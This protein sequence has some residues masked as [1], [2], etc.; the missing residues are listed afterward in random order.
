MKPCCG[1]AR[2]P[3]SQHMFFPHFEVKD[4]FETNVT[5]GYT[6]DE[7]KRAYSYDNG[8][9]G[10]GVRVAVISALDN[11]ALNNNLSVFS[12]T[13]N[14]PQTE[15]R[16]FYPYGRSEN[17]SRQWLIESS[18]DTQWIHA[19]APSSDI[20][21]VFSPTANVKSLLMCAEYAAEQLNCDIVCMCFGTQESV[22]DTELAELMGGKGIFVA[23]SGDSGGKVSFPSN[24]PYCI[25]V[26]GTNLS[27]SSVT[28]RRISETAWKNGGGGKSDVF[29]IPPYQG[30]FFNIYGMADGMRGTPD[31]SLMANYSP[32]APVY[33]S[34]LGGWTNV[35]GTSLSAACFSGICACI[36][37]KH[38]EITKS[39]D[40]LSFLYSK[41][42]GDGYSLPQYNFY[43]ITIG[44]SGDNYAMQGWDFATG[45]GSPV[46]HRL[47]T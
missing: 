11:E 5:G 1:V 14:L 16:T 13:Y 17:I 44:K 38:P 9:D 34:Q 18:L 31:V 46:I 7:L 19:F 12:K 22:A 39:S 25:S 36:K 42:G 45:L 24:S 2:F 47:V 29:E 33:V 15:I 3:L 37:E 4:T 32:G 35:G 28:G 27:L 41:A 30:R 40:M 21:A 43:D 23:S 10:K 8:A 6:P 20:V 26:G